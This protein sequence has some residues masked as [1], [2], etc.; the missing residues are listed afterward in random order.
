LDPV[1]DVV[2]AVSTLIR[3]HRLN[4]WSKLAANVFLSG[5]IS[6][7]VVCG[8]TLGTVA[9]KHVPASLCWVI[10]VGAGMVAAGVSMTVLWRTSPLTKGLQIVLPMA[11]ATEELKA[12]SI[13]IIRPKQ[14]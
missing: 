3:L 11:E 4:D 13:T 8:G 1:S 6:F 5:S 9:Y 14:E 12:D 2:G 10:G 7:L